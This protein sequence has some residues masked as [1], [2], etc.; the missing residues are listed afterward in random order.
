[1]KVRVRLARRH[2][3]T[4]GDTDAQ[5]FHFGPECLGDSFCAIAWGTGKRDHKFVPAITAQQISWPV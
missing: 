1:M 4:N 3:K 2:A 5:A